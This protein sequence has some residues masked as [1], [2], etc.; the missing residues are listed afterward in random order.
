MGDVMDVIA[1]QVVG[2]ASLWLRFRDGLQGIT[3]LADELKG[4]S[5]FE[6]LADPAVFAAAWLNPATGTVEWPT[7]AD[8]S[9][10]Y[11]YQRVAGHRAPTDPPSA[12]NVA[13]VAELAA[14]ANS[15]PGDGVESA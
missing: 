6:P 12:D 10:S 1:M 2:P 3:D 15:H 4:G 11:L 7:G 9:P 8:F 14:S 13:L 5:V